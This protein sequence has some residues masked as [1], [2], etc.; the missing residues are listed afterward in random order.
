MSGS[1]FHFFH[2]W[3]KACM[4]AVLLLAWMHGAS[5]AAQDA[6]VQEAPKPLKVSPK[7]LEVLRKAP[8]PSPVPVPASASEAGR[9]DALRG[10][11]L[12]ANPWLALEGKEPGLLG[13]GQAQG[14]LKEVELDKLRECGNPS[15]LN[16][17]A[18]EFLKLF[19]GKLGG[20]FEL[21]PACGS[22]QREVATGV[23]LWISPTTGPTDWDR[24]G[25]RGELMANALV[26]LAH[27]I[28]QRPGGA[29]QRVAQA[30]GGVKTIQTVGLSKWEPEKRRAE[31]YHQVK[32]CAPVLGC[33]DAQRQSIVLEA[34]DSAPAWP[35]PVKAGD[36]TIVSAHSVVLGA[37]WSRLKLGA[38]LP[39]IT[40]PTPYGVLSA[41]PYFSYLSALLPVDDVQQHLS[42]PPHYDGWPVDEGRVLPIQH[43]VGYRRPDGTK[44]IREGKKLEDVFGRGKPLAVIEAMA[45]RR[46]RQGDAGPP[47]DWPEGQPWLMPEQRLP[48][49]GW[50]SQ[51]AFGG[52]GLRPN[53]PFWRSS[54]WP[55]VPPRPDF[56]Y[57]QPRSPL[58]GSPVGHFAAG[59]K[60][61]YVL[62]I[63]DLPFPAPPL[64]TSFSLTITVTPSITAGFASQLHVYSN[65]TRLDGACSKVGEFWSDCG[66]AQVGLATQAQAS[67]AADIDGSVRLKIGF[68]SFVP[69]LNVSKAFHVPLLDDAGHDP[70]LSSSGLPPA[71]ASV[72]HLAERVSGPPWL[73]SVTGASGRTSGNVEGWVD[74]CLVSP[75]PSLP[76]PPPPAHE[77]GN[78]DDL[79]PDM[80]PCNICIAH[81]DVPGLEPTLLYEVKSR[82][83]DAGRWVCEG[84]QNTGCHDMCSF[85]PV[86][87]QFIQ[88]EKSALAIFTD[89]KERDR[90]LAPRRVKIK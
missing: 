23:D 8:D 77:P 28:G 59:A 2:G 57:S 69:E 87:R 83:P 7:V 38:E 15:P 36:Y 66:L 29:W 75:P 31:L 86:T 63:D 37:D 6:G 49:E 89:P 58:E 55:G 47:P 1:K 40:I 30:D 73:Q 88:V 32:V 27:D 46:V 41:Q 79:A 65:E 76:R 85:N 52:R 72:I 74:S 5:A 26:C 39:K 51:L 53:D 19:V 68:A 24:M 61:V 12:G 17:E 45:N 70:A 82:A 18:M 44:Y 35:H 25:G 22:F 84:A 20:K 11:V 78:A 4:C 9:S 48:L 13:R 33:L 50:T 43:S 10:P 16:R 54:S 3:T 14:S 71:Q 64:M 67:S 80:L 42:L 21:D 56:D 81:E 90:C 60:F 62:G 34:R